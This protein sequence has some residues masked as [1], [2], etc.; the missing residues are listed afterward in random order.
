MS[1]LYVQPWVVCLQSQFLLVLLFSESFSWIF[2]YPWGCFED[3]LR[4]KCAHM[5]IY[6]DSWFNRSNLIKASLYKDNF[7]FSSDELI[8]NFGKKLNVFLFWIIDWI[9]FVFFLFIKKGWEGYFKALLISIFI[10]KR[11]LVSN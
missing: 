5:I 7:I 1:L 3:H 9:I 2:I 6:N 11:I 8:P 10:N 4:T